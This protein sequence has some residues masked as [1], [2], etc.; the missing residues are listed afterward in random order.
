MSAVF[1]PT[2]R[3]SDRLHRKGEAPQPTVGGRGALGSM[4]DRPALQS[5]T[6]L[7]VPGLTTNEAVQAARHD[8]PSSRPLRDPRKETSAN[9]HAR[10]GSRELER[11]SMADRR[12]SL[13]EHTSGLGAIVS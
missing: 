3:A 11:S 12:V 4:A 6:A 9:G 13:R 5:R 8:S 2:G 7:A 1:G 10:E